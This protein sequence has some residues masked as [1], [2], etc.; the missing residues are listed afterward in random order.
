VEKIN[1]IHIITGLESHGAEMMLFKLVSNID[2]SQF[3]TRIIT[4][5]AHDQLRDKFS[6]YV[7]SIDIIDLNGVIKLPIGF[8]KL[9]LKLKFYNPN[10]VQTW[11]YHADLVGGVASKLLNLKP[12]IWNIRHSF[13]KGEGFKTKVIVKLL[14]F[15]SIPIPDKILS[16]SFRSVEIHKAIGYCSYKLQVIPNG[17]DLDLF[18]PSEL[19]RESYRRSL[20]IKKGTF[21]IGMVARYHPQKDHLTF[22]LAVKELKDSLTVERSIKFILCGTGVN[23]SKDLHDAITRLSLTDDIILLG[24]VEK[25]E[26][27]YNSLDLFTL[28]SSYGEGFPNV[29]GEAMCCGLSCVATDVGDSS[30][31]IGDSGSIVQV[32][33]YKGLSIKWLNFIEKTDFQREVL[34]MKSRQRMKDLF[35]IDTI[36]RKYEYFYKDNLV[37]KIVKL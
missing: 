15:L 5:T 34:G 22:L 10:I 14:A 6:P 13:H 2:Q 30:H 7:E 32:L 25:I 16:N 21:L 27:L 23:D 11:M 28:T 12:I 33:D 9:L 26:R 4:L 37:T 3:S 35:S 17:F 36:T 18:K 1:I 19:A 8:I 31:V 24:E 29:L 20:G